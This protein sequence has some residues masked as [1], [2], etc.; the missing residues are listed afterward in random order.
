ML[1]EHTICSTWYSQLYA[2][3]HMTH[4]SMTNKSEV[5]NKIDLEIIE[6]NELKWA[7]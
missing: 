7:F 2:L 1:N 3:S 5:E 6:Y 4:Q